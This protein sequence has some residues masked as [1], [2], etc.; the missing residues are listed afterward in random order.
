MRPLLPVMR[1]RSGCGIIAARQFFE[2]VRSGRE[3]QGGPEGLEW[4]QVRS[5]DR[6]RYHRKGPAAIMPAPISSTKVAIYE[7][8]LNRRPDSV[9][10]VGE[11]R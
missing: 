5:C 7:T 4:I 8:R 11:L 3:D 6:M 10:P 9:L 1:L 2:A